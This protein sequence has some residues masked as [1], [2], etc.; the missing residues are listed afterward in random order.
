L[1]IPKR[2]AKI[3]EKGRYVIKVEEGSVSMEEDKTKEERY[4]EVFIAHKSLDE[5]VQKLHEKTHLTVEEEMEMALLK[6][7]KLYL[8]DLMESIKQ[9]P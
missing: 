3:E 6:K 8:K 5:K 7:K 4:N 1:T 9:E 2:G